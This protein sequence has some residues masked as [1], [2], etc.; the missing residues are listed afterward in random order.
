M[1]ARRPPAEP[2]SVVVLDDSP[3]V[4][5]DGSSGV[6]VVVGGAVVS[7]SNAEGTVAR[8]FEE[9]HRV[10]SQ[11]R[12]ACRFPRSGWASPALLCWLGTCPAAAK[13]EAATRRPRPE[14]T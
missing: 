6:V 4:I 12:A 5:V 8:T 14:D 11:V 9:T 13:D 1:F 7:D 3:V 10:S 2:S